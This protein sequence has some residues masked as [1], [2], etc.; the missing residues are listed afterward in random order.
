[1]WSNKIENPNSSWFNLRGAWLTNVLIVV[2]MKISFSILPGVSPEISWTLT[3]LT[4]NIVSTRGEA[5]AGAVTHIRA[6]H[7][8]LLP[9][10]A[11]HAL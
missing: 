1:M 3:N 9:L 5:V 4:Y 8:L 7:L 2:V 11:G 10:A 6:V